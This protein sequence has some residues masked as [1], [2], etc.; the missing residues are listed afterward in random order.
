MMMTNIFDEHSDHP[1][2]D[3]K[4]TERRQQTVPIFIEAMRLL[5][6]KPLTKTELRDLVRFR[7]KTFLRLLKGL[8]ECGTVIRRG[9][10]TR[11]NPYMYT[12]AENYFSKKNVG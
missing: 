11:G 4:R 6:T 2:F 10:G 7:K 5:Q 1:L 8:I 12:L 9:D 3:L